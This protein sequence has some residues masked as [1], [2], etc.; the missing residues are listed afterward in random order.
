MET[1]KTKYKRG[2][3]V[4]VYTRDGL[5]LCKIYKIIIW[6]EHDGKTE[7]AYCMSEYGDS[8]R[9]SQI[10]A[11]YEAAKKKIRENENQLQLALL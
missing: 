10:M 9:E 2:D 7:I 5:Q 1:V 8:Y 6:L 11:N 3:S 4:Y